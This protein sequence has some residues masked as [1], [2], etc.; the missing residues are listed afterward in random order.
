MEPDPQFVDALKRLAA[1]QLEPEDWLEWWKDHAD[2]A[3]GQ[4]NR[5]QWLRLKPPTPGGFG[6]P[7]RCALVSQQEAFAL[8]SKWGIEHARSDRYEQEW[9]AHFAKFTAEQKAKRAQ[10]Q[11]KF[12]PGLDRLKAVYPKLARFLSRQLD[13]VQELADPASD[14]EIAQWEQS[15]GLKL[16]ESYR[17]FLAC[18]RSL[19]YGDTLQMGLLFTFQHPDEPQLP[20]A[21]LI[22][23]AEYWLEADGDQ[24][25]F[26][27]AEPGSEPAV[28]YYSHSEPS[29]RAMAKDLDAWLESLPRVLKDC[30]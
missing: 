11:K 2:W 18:T 14:E 12:R 4:L 21:G 13:A 8:L 15:Y 23:F 9:E 26:A 17:R 24:A 1:G 19:V 28:L 3:A 20:S 5:G 7:S 10:Q 22:C 25:L 6:P 30:S 29:V 16:P 27:A